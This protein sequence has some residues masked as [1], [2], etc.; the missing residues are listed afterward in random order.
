M[1]N[2][3]LVDLLKVEIDRMNIR[4]RR[5]FKAVLT[6]TLPQYIDQAAKV[7]RIRSQNVTNDEKNQ[8]KTD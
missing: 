6:Q 8:T 3:K 4:E 1:E 5:Q 2:Y 7:A